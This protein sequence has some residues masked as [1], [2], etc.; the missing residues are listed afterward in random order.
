MTI[1]FQVSSS[2]EQIRNDGHCLEIQPILDRDCLRVSL[3]ITD[4]L[5]PSPAI[6]LDIEE[7]SEL[8][9]VLARVQQD[10]E[11][12]QTGQGPPA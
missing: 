2:A 11:S 10:L 6:E 7:I 5:N 3:C 12:N 4:A 9:D 8:R 1:T